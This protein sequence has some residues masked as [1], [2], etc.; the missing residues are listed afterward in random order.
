MNNK[1]ENMTFV[2]GRFCIK[3][4]A[5]LILAILIVL[6]AAST[7]I[8]QSRRQTIRMYGIAVPKDSVVLKSAVDGHV[9]QLLC[10]EGQ[11]VKKGQ[12][13]VQ[14]EMPYGSRSIGHCK[15]TIRNHGHA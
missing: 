5:F 12:V 1:I 2:A 15:T 10:Y 8:G 13:L 14:L 9:D 11:F 6:F 3:K 4:M 7:V